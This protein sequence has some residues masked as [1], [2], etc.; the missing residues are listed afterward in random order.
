VKR[1]DLIRHLEENHCFL[2]REGSKHSVYQNAVTKKRTTVP[3]HAEIDR[4]LAKL[5]CKQ[6]EITKPF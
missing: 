1:K 5:I 6:L 3:R 4:N 2:L